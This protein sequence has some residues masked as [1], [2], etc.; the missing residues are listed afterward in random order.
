MEQEISNNMHILERM[1]QGRQLLDQQYKVLQ[2][3]KPISD[4]KPKCEMIVEPKEYVNEFGF[5]CK[6]Q[7]QEYENL[8]EI[9]RNISKEEEDQIFSIF[10][11]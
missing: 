11:S 6:V 7:K 2:N 1:K 8:N 4:D 3:S 10:N 5:K 9:M